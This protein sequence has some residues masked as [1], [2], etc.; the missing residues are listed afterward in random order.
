LSALAARTVFEVLPGIKIFSGAVNTAA[1]ERNGRTLLIDSGD[2]TTAPDGSTAEWALFTHHHRDQA[3]GAPHLVRSGTKLVVPAKERRLFEDADRFWDTADILLDH[4]MLNLR[5]LTFSLRESVPVARAVAGGDTHSWQGLDFQVIDTPGHTDGSISYVVRIGG[6]TVAFTG[7][8]IYGPGQILEIYS[9]QKRHKGMRGD[10]WGFGGAIGELKTSLD[11]VLDQKP[12]ILVPSHGVIIA[13]PAAAV[14]ELK[15]NLDAAMDNFFTTAAWR[16][17]PYHV[18]EYPR[19]ERPEM[20]PS[21]PPVS[22]PPWIRH[23]AATSKA[24]VAADKSVFLS[25]CGDA[26][27]I[28]ELSRLQAAGEITSID[29]VW[30]THYHDDHTEF[31]NTLRRRFGTKVY[32]QRELMA[33][34]ENPTAYRMPAL[35]PESI[36]VDRV[37]EHGE[38]IDWRGF[39]LTAYHFPGQTLFHAGLLAE[40]NG[41]KAFFTGDSFANWGIGDYCSQNRCFLGPE[42]GFRK[43]LRVLLDTKPDMLVAAHWGPLPVSAEYVRKTDA[44]LQQRERLFA[45]V[46]PHDN[47]N[48]G[49]DPCWIRA[50]PYRQSALPGA[51]VVIEARVMNHSAKPK[52]VSAELKLPHGWQSAVASGAK[53]IPARTEGRIRLTAAAPPDTGRRRHVV[54]VAVAIEGHPLGEFAEAIVNVLS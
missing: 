8:L 50:Y 5:S 9:L 7:D 22:Y 2:L 10:Y 33:I 39:R 38:S 4:E 27:V 15:E 18:D 40:R 17:S 24:I 25:D 21:L 14:A 13:N 45:A 6:K 20:W 42:V 54:G 51:Q 36:R 30:I 35:Y 44:M 31:V 16:I 3:E 11:A 52:G 34:I 29:G 12:D 53:V 49:L 46:F 48:F 32:V 43:C 19:E 23:I 41:F 28:D 26:A 1:I 37:M 47:V